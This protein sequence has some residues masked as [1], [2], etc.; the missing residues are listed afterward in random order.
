[1]GTTSS[2]GAGALVAACHKRDFGV[3]AVETCSQSYDSRVSRGRGIA[4]RSMSTY[5][6]HV[7]AAGGGIASAEEEQFSHVDLSAQCSE[8]LPSIFV[9]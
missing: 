5:V 8:Q 9:F 3:E 6:L 1:M 7:A 2:I 4:G